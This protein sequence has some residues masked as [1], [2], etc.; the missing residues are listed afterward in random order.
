MGLLASGL[1][2][3]GPSFFCSAGFI[4]SIFANGRCYFF[5][6]SENNPIGENFPSGIQPYKIGLWCYEDVLNRN[7][8]I[9]PY[10][11][12]EKFEAARGLGT[13]SSS[14]GLVLWLF[15]IFAGCKPFPPVAFKFIGLLGV[16]NCMLQSLVF[17]LGQSEVCAG[18]C[19]LNIGANC[20]IS[21][22]VMYF[23]GGLLSCV[24]GKDVE[25]AGGEGEGEGE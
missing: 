22:A 6:L 18:G 10:S 20:A 19:E 14:I 12:D 25:E 5:Q 1:M 24:A 23:V 4:L 21:A 2:C 13:A 3:L 8:D 17:L 7:W 16:V 15:Y 11:F 9:R